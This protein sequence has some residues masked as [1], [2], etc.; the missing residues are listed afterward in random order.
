M[1][2]TSMRQSLFLTNS[3]L[4][5]I[6]TL[7]AAPALGEETNGGQ[8]KNVAAIV[9]TYFHNSHADVIVS[10]L[11][12][13]DTLD[14]QGRKSPLRLASLYID[15]VSANDIGVKL[16]ADHQ[17]PVYRSIREALTLGGDKLAVDGVL[18]I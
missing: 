16:A 18:L 2:Q 11:L 17:V 4:A 15:Q 5:V 6:A 8:N 3:I 9:T 1:R 7:G 13:T 12:Q 10:R 14:G